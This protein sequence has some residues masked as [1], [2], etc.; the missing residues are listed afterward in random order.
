M[1]PTQHGQLSRQVG[2]GLQGGP[3]VTGEGQREHLRHSRIGVLCGGWELER[4][5]EAVGNIE[6]HVSTIKLEDT[7]G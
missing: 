1:A 6:R 5:E 2:T 4:K 7:A 3:G